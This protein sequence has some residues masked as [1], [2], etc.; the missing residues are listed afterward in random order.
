MRLRRAQ[1]LGSPGAICRELPEKERSNSVR[2][3]LL[4]LV[5]AETFPFVAFLV[6]TSR[7]QCSPQTTSIPPGYGIEKTFPDVPKS[8]LNKAWS[9]ECRGASVEGSWANERQCDSRD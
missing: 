3:F 8:S 6:L 7:P 9:R 4:T 1:A 5:A 2:T